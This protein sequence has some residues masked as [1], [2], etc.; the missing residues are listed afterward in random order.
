LK[1]FKIAKGIR[2]LLNT[3]IQTLP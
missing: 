3:V 2:A 1:L